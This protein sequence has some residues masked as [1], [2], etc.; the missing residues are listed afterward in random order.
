MLRIRR[1]FLSPN[2]R[3]FLVRSAS[4]SI[5]VKENVSFDRF[6]FQFLLCLE[7]NTI[8][9]GIEELFHGMAG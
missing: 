3:K 8:Y 7:A 2:L 5:D 4:T 9:C 1:V 6:F